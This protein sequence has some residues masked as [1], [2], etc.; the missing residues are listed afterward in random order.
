MSGPDHEGS[1]APTGARVP[2]IAVIGRQ[3]VGKSTLVNRLFGGREAI[4]HDLP[5]VTRDRLE[6]ETTWRGRRFS[7]VDTAGYLHGASGIEALAGDQA[8]RAVALADLVMLVVDAQAGITEEDGALARRLRRSHVPVIVVANKVD[9]DREEADAAA[10][11]SLGLG[12]P[13]PV[14][15]M[16][17]RAAGDLLDRIVQLLPDAPQEDASGH[18]AEPRF[19]LVGRPN[20]G[21]SSLFNRL[22]GV[23]RSLVFEEAGTTRDAIDALVEWPDGPARFVDTAGMRR[24]TRVRGIEYFSV[25]RATQA[26]ERAQVAVVVLDATGGFT[27][28]DKKIANIVIEAGRALMLVANKWDLVE[29]KDDLYADLTRTSMQFTAAP[30]MRVSA[31]T[32]RGVHR[33]PPVLIDLHARWSSRVSTSKVNEVIQRAQR[34]R[35]TSRDAGTLHYATQVSTGPPGFVIF[36]GARPPDAGYRRYVEGRLRRAFHLQGVP[37][38]VHYRPRK[39]RSG[40]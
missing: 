33:L 27:I 4:A 11:H 12:E 28:E 40:R 32:G 2:R 15:G 25:V 10:F 19:A 29:D 39:S 8:D 16:H 21:K 31:L 26:I 22:V 13:F 36:G 20:A 23:E 30:V 37:I 24:Q 35:P 34:E 38:R 7:L 18:G 1:R 14:S 5:G 6:L 3:N 17:G 9:T